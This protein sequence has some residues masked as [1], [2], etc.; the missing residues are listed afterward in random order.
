M[1][2]DFS[3]RPALIYSG[4]PGFSGA[5]AFTV[6]PGGT[7]SLQAFAGREDGLQLTRTITLE[8]D[9]RVKVRDVF[10][11]TGS[12]P[13]N[14]SQ[15]RFWLGPMAL[16]EEYTKVRGFEFLGVDVQPAIGGESVLYLSK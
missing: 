10:A 8:S 16:P 2:L 14:M 11:N 7:D 5:D 4:L 13:V 6:N 3:E 9:Y 1:I 15:H 12:A